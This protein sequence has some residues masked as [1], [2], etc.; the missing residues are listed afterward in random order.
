MK[1]LVWAVGGVFVAMVLLACMALA[2]ILDPGGS[3]VDATAVASGP[4]LP[5]P[6]IPG[7]VALSPTAKKDIEAG[8]IDP[9]V[10]AL[11]S[12]SPW[13]I[14]VGVAKT[15]HRLCVHGSDPCRYSNHI[16]GRAID[17]VRVGGKPV[18]ATNQ[19]ARAFVNWLTTYAPRPDEVGSPF[20]EFRSQNPGRWFSDADHR[21]HLHI[22]WDR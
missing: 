7:H 22:G 16:F 19:E 9:R 3:L 11:L 8:I 14:Q 15:G 18:D 6:A 13:D 21:D 5:I 10:T 20:P 2:M 4:F 17:I 12:A 1:R